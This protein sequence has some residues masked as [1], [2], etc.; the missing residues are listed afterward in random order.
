MCV[1]EFHKDRLHLHCNGR[2]GL[3]AYARNYLLLWPLLLV[4]NAKINTRPNE[5]IAIE[6]DGAVS[7][8]RRAAM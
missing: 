6:I 7:I 4:L 2:V 8:T 3:A 1:R 5:T